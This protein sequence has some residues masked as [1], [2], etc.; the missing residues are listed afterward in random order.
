MAD[1]LLLLAKFTVLCLC[2]CTG[3][4]PS[5]GAELIKIAAGLFVAIWLTEAVRK[6]Q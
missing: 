2:C 6:E 4:L 1:R 5:I 3:L